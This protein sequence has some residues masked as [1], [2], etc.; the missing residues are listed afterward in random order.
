MIDD[1]IE[2]FCS[3]LEGVITHSEFFII[4]IHITQVILTIASTSAV[5]SSS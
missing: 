1:I 5:F 3:L 4:I 2:M